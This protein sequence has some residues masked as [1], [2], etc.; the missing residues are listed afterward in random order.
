MAVTFNDTFV[1]SGYEC[2]Y[3]TGGGTTFSALNYS[4]TLN[5]FSNT[6]TVDDAVYFIPRLGGGYFTGI[7]IITS[8]DF[9]GIVSSSHTI[10]WEYYNGTTWATLPSI[11]DGSNGLTQAGEIT[12]D[13]PADWAIYDYA[14]SS[15]HYRLFMVRARLSA[16]SG[17]TSGGTCKPITVL[18][19][20]PYTINVTG[21]E[22]I[23]PASLKTISDT[24]G[25]GA[26]TVDNQTYT[27]VHGLRLDGSGVTFTLNGLN[28]QYGTPEKPCFWYNYNAKWLVNYNS[29]YLSNGTG[30][31]FTFYVTNTNGDTMSFQTDVEDSAI[32]NVTFV[33]M[34]GG[35]TEYARA[36]LYRIA[37]GGANGVSNQNFGN[38]FTYATFPYGTRTKYER[39]IFTV[40]QYLLSGPGVTYKNCYFNGRPSE[41]PTYTPVAENCT[42]DGVS[43]G[44]WI[45]MRDTT[46]GTYFFDAVNCEFPNGNKFNTDSMESNPTSKTRHLKR[47]L[48]SKG[49]VT[50]YDTNGDVIE[51]AKVYLSD[52]YGNP[53]TLVLTDIYPTSKTLKASN[54]FYV[55]DSTNFVVGEYYYILG[56]YIKVTSKPNGTSI[57]ADRGQFNSKVT[58]MD[59]KG[60]TYER[61]YH[62]PEYLETD[63]NGETSEF[64][65][66]E[67]S[68]YRIQDNF[69]KYYH[70]PYTITV[71]KDGY[72]TQVETVTNLDNYLKIV[73]TLKPSIPIRISTEGPVLALAPETGSSSLLKKL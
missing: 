48:S 63:S 1:T 66:L 4:T 43:S 44:D 46:T 50:V 69:Y 58:D 38:V 33:K 72:E 73:I 45:N 34:V 20:R 7:K 56:E 52:A 5:L 60:Y 68:A 10:V 24:N 6:P 41:D 21:T 53:T 51:G 65:L 2:G 22:S 57:I 13:L 23:T 17:V 27:F 67:M 19:I 55:N 16:F 12:W 18:S 59:S 30:S 25:W 32:N 31:V 14:Y 71:V 15:F 47:I 11:S 35:S 29:R 28:L 70:A 54:T 9:T 64:K 37:H 26:V 3:T 8:G 62:A 39:C 61:F 36:H 40:L 49:I 42:F